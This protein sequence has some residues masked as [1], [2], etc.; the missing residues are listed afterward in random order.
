MSFLAHDLAHSID[1]VFMIHLAYYFIMYMHNYLKALRIEILHRLSEQ[2]ASYSL[3][4]VFNKLSTV[5]LDVPPLLS[6]LIKSF[7]LDA[8]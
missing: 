1:F 5:G 3:D 2:V 6:D 4:N 8:L 7:V